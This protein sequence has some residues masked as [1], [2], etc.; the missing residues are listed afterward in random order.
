MYAAL[1]GEAVVLTNGLIPPKR[2]NRTRY[3]STLQLPHIR[4]DTYRICRCFIGKSS[5]RTIKLCLSS[6]SAVGAINA[7]PP[8]RIII[9]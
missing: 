7:M 8:M 9:I 5:S 6:S 1:K 4:T 2:N 3:A